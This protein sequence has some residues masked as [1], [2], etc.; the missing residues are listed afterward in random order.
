M[1][2]EDNTDEVYTTFFQKS[3]VALVRSTFSK[4]LY[5]ND[6]QMV[7]TAQLNKTYI[8]KNGVVYVYGN[9][10]LILSQFLQFMNFENHTV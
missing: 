6:I 3:R 8:S 2:T 5:Y 10:L 9:G 1:I 4:T 7:L